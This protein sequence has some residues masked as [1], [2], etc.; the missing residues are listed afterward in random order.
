M[1]VTYCVI[2]T[3]KEGSSKR[4][5]ERFSDEKENK[6]CIKGTLLSFILFHVPFI[7]GRVMEALHDRLSC[8][9]RTLTIKIHY[10]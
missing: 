7:S 3:P 4:S 9:S 5:I 6:H 1:K 2:E 8:K 10:D